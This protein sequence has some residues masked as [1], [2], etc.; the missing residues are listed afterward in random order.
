MIEFLMG[1]IARL[2]TPVVSVGI[3]L[4]FEVH[5]CRSNAGAIRMEGNRVDRP[6][7]I[8]KDPDVPP[9]GNIPDPHCL[10]IPS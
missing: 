7:V 9:G 3:C 10:V 4:E 8:I 5:A 6:I 1:E 2:E